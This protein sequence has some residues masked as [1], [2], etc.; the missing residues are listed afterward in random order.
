MA[1][2]KARLVLAAFAGCT[3]GLGMDKGRTM[4]I[5]GVREKRMGSEGL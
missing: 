5:C 3:F 1:C 2:E 4:K